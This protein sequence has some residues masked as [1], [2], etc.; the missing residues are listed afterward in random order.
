MERADAPYMPFPFLLGYA[1]AV[2]EQDGHEVRVIDACAERMD[3]PT[4]LEQT[5]TFGPDFVMLEIS[6]PSLTEDL[7]TVAGLREGGFDGPIV[8]GGLHKPLYTTDFL[9]GLPL[10]EGTLVGEYEYTLKELLAALAEDPRGPKDAVPGLIWRRGDEL[11]DGGR[12]HSQEGLDELPWPARHLFPMERYHDL[13]GGIPAPSVQLWA[14]RGCSFTCD[15]CA[16]PQILYADN[17][18]R[19]RSADAVADEVVSLLEQGYASVYFDD[20]TFNLGRKR[21]EDLTRAFEK[22]GITAPWAFMGRADTCRPDQYADLA[23]TGLTAVKFGV[24]SADTSRLKRIGKNLDVEMVRR[25]VQA[26]HDNGIKVHLTFMF[27]LPGETLETMQRTLDL[28]YELDP[29]SAQFTIAVPFPGSRFYDQMIGEGRLAAED[30]DLDALDGYRTGVVSTDALEAEQIISFVHGVHRRWE[31]RPR[32][33]GKAPVIPVSEIGGSGLSI[34]LLVR[35]GQGGWLRTALKEALAQEGPSREIVIVA[36]SSDPSLESAAAEICDWATFLDAEPGESLAA[37]ANRVAPACTGRWISLF[38]SGALPVAGWLT[39]VLSGAKAHPD[40]GALAV[41]LQAPNVQI[42]R[43]PASTGLSVARWGRV[44]DSRVT[45]EAPVGG[46]A[47]IAGLFSRALL[48]DTGGF[49][50]DLPIDLA[51]ADLCLRGLLLGYRSWLIEGPGISLTAPFP[52]PDPE[53]WGAGRLKMLLRSVPREAWRDAALPIAAELVG[54]LYRS[55]R[56]GG[57]PIGVLRGFVAAA[58]HASSTIE[59][60]RRTLGRRRVGPGWMGE[61]FAASERDMAHCW[62]QRA[63]QRLA[64]T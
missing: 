40:A 49:D 54:D 2:L 58:T 16:W 36:E 17:A 38:H 46:V 39:S 4:F 7:R 61:A 27:G 56:D 59:E 15:F 22:R 26:A 31:T 53:Q 44:L 29:D 57:S 33:A 41:S 9:A 30:I 60:R 19:V 35:A 12:K 42:G 50:P 45:G 8:L 21:T 32:P 24:E 47:S 34:G 20:D 25:S 52:T 55:S 64:A 62:W 1:A 10:I 43:V 18:Y 63:Q 48:E 14:S 51:D 11:L 28:A 6:T 3:R 5:A 37:M 13:P 23:K